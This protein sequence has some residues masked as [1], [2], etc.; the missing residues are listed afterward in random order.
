MRAEE[1]DRIVICKSCRRPEY[2]GQMRWLNGE[3]HL[4]GLLPIRVGE[5]ARRTIQMERPGR[6]PSYHA[7]LQ[8]TGGRIE[9]WDY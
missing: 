9:K 7:G 2:W 4:P 8:Q 5:H 3:M 1:K 6:K